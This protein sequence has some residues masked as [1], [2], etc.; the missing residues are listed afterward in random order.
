MVQHVENPDVEQGELMRLGQPA[1]ER[2]I[3]AQG[4]IQEV[5]PRLL[6]GDVEPGHLAGCPAGNQGGHHVMLCDTAALEQTKMQV[7]AWRACTPSSS[8]PP[9]NCPGSKSRMSTQAR[10]R[11]WSRSARP[12]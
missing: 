2:R 1:I 10:T 6:L 8:N 9:I 5:L 4:G 11:C 12:A 7:V 3:Q